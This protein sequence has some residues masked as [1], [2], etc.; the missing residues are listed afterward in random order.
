MMRWMEHA[1]RM[2]DIKYVYTKESREYMDKVAL[3]QI[4]FEYCGFPCQFS[5]Y[6]SIIRG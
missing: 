1:A 2:L 3:G 5:F 6:L 4:V